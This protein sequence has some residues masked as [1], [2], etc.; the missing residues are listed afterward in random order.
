MTQ[1]V[2]YKRQIVHHL[3][4][5]FKHYGI[6]IVKTFLSQKQYTILY[7]LSIERELLLTKFTAFDF[8]VSTQNSVAIAN[9]VFQHHNFKYLLLFTVLS[10]NPLGFFFFFGQSRQR[11]VDTT[12]ILMFQ[13][14]LI[15]LSFNDRISLL[16]IMSHL[17]LTMNQ[18]SFVKVARFE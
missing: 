5:L 10:K 14:S 2:E 17:F 16:K 18:K 12:F 15:Q 7:H 11:E 9:H 1:N 3:F 6:P 13:I 8:D 4:T